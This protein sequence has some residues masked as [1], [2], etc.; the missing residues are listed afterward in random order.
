MLSIRRVPLA[1]LGVVVASAGVVACGDDDGDVAATGAEPVLT[2]SIDVPFGLDQIAGIEPVGRPAV[3]DHEYGSNAAEP[4]MA[5]SVRAAYRVTADDPPA[6]VR[7][8]LAGLD[9]L[10]LDDG[11]IRGIDDPACRDCS[12]APGL[13]IEASG[14]QDEDAGLG[15]RVDVQLWVADDGP[16]LLVDATRIVDS[17]AP[18][19]TPTIEEEGA[20]DGSD[21]PS[22]VEAS[23]GSAGDVLFSEQGDAIH[24]PEGTR[25]LL[26]TFPTWCGT[27]GSTSVIAAEDGAAAVQAMLDEARTRSEWGEIEGP[28][29]TTTDGVEVTR[30]DFVISAG[31]WEFNL[32]AVRGPDDPYATVYVTSC[33]D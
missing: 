26:P 24:L 14:R 4:I 5:R 2:T 20:V 22:P 15:D 3:F 8:V 23:G 11:S 31:G 12:G 13:W 33:A 27:G 21:S 18:P 28:D 25:A 7:D 29:V 30:A 16:V 17:A 6:V 9:G 19:R 10:S 1:V 32:L